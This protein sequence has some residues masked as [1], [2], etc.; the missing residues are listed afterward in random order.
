MFYLIYKIINNVNRKTYI[1]IHKTK[2]KNDGYLGSG[3]LIR[4]AIKKHGVENFYK[5]ILFECSSFEEMLQKELE[6]VVVDS[7]KTYNLIPG[8]GN[9]RF[10]EASRLGVDARKKLEKDLKWLNNFR[11]KLKAGRRR[12]ID[13]VSKEEWSRRG[14][15]A[16]QTALTNNG[17]YSFQGKKH[18]KKTKKLIGKKNSVAQKGTGNSQYGTMWIRN[19]ATNESQKILKNDTIPIGW[20]RGRS[21]NK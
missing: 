1:G 11:S 3:K 6:F 20:I 7:K 13:T 16:N 15:R 8:G 17:K 2:D 10:G 18:S 9:S 19:I 12:Y 14:K 5:E 21:M 4:R